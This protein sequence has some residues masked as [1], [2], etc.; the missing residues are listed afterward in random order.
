MKKLEK[1]ILNEIYSFETKQTLIELTIR[2]FIIIG[3]TVGAILLGLFVIQELIQQQTLDIFEIFLEDFGIIK[4][5]IVEVFG[6][7]F[8]EAPLIEIFL[9]TIVIVISFILIIKLIQNF[10]KVKNKINSLVKFW[11]AH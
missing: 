2:L 5:N 11:L 7:F 1:K 3:F 6:T 8:Q 4:E 9:A 10:A